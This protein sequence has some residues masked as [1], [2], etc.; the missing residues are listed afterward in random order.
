MSIKN[1]ARLNS[2]GFFRSKHLNDVGFKL[3][4]KKGV[5]ELNGY[6]IQL[7]SGDSL[8]DIEYKINKRSKDTGISARIVKVTQGCRLV[9]E[10]KKKDI[11]IYDIDHV[12]LNLYRNKCIGKNTKN[13]IQIVRTDP[14]ILNNVT[15]HYKYSQKQKP[16][17]RLELLTEQNKFA[18]SA[19]LLPLE[20]TTEQELNSS[21]FY[22]YIED[23]KELDYEDESFLS[24]SIGSNEED[25]ILPEN[26]DI[27][28]DS[29]IHIPL[30]SV[31]TPL[32]VEDL[33][34]LEEE[35]EEQKQPEHNYSESL[36]LYLVQ[37][38]TLK[39]NLTELEEEFKELTSENE[40]L[41]DRIYAKEST[42]V[43]LTGKIKQQEQELLSTEEDNKNELTQIDIIKQQLKDILDDKLFS[44]DYEL[45]A[46]INT[47]NLTR[48]DVEKLL[49][50]INVQEENLLNKY[51]D[52][53]Y[54][55]FKIKVDL[56]ESQLEY[57]DLH[58]KLRDN[59]NE[60][61]RNIYNREQ[62]QEELMKINVI[63]GNTQ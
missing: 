63:Y 31:T 36:E 43:N 30:Q 60:L 38:E 47:E 37:I 29:S 56:E 62:I 23:G 61:Q 57:N 18:I 19:I 52:I 58:N 13:L 9:L 4:F 32:V 53:E 25:N 22:K 45:L 54:S 14:K 27:K 16:V 3:P 28:I 59:E 49:Q 33:I 10:S 15:I 44:D 46:I 8:K 55:V 21:P 7:N 51:K 11:K 40:E 24:F 20:K 35:V 1:I 2:S 17:Q 26:E 6:K 34:S 42:I 48:E 41:Q 50:K 12:L 39:N 5:F